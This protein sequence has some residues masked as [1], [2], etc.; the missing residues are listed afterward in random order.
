MSAV[1][2]KQNADRWGNMLTVKETT[3]FLALFVTKYK[4]DA[5]F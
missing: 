5:F 2:Q 1:K 3:L 4:I